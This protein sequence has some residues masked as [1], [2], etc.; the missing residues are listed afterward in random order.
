[1]AGKDYDAVSGTL[2]FAPSQ[3]AETVSVAILDDAFDEGNDD[4]AGHGV[5]L[6]SWVRL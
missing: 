1:M 4:Q 3:T 5:M 2:D 6:R